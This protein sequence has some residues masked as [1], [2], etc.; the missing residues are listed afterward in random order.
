MYP[1]DRSS[2]GEARQR[3]EVGVRRCMPRWR[4]MER[5]CGALRLKMFI[6]TTTREVI[7][8]PAS[9]PAHLLCSLPHHNSS[10]YHNVP[11]KDSYSK[12]RQGLCSCHLFLHVHH[13]AYNKNKRNLDPT[14]LLV[15]G[16]TCRAAARNSHTP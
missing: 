9:T 15:Y 12:S 3:K 14:Y 11:S 10:L 5:S 16:K 7:C 6:F 8:L 13:T 1:W 2:R 4:G